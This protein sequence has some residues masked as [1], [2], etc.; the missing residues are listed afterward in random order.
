MMSERREATQPAQRRH[1][2]TN[3]IIDATGDDTATV[4]CY[5]LMGTTTD[6]QLTLPIT[7]R[8]DDDLVKDDQGRWRFVKRVLTVD[9]A[10]A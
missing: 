5:L 2:A 8:Y 10:L 4:A 3:V 9:G 6:G 7:G 1:L